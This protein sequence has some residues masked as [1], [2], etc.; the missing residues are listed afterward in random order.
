VTNV[1]PTFVARRVH[2]LRFGP[3]LL[4]NVGN[5]VS[6][7]LDETRITT[8]RTTVRNTLL[9][10]VVGVPGRTNGRVARAG[11]VII[12]SDDVIRGRGTDRLVVVVGS[13]D[14]RTTGIPDVVVA[15]SGPDVGIN[16]R[17]RT[18]INNNATSTLPTSSQRSQ[19]DNNDEG[20]E[21]GRRSQ[22]SSAGLFWCC[23]GRH[24]SLF[25]LFSSRGA[26]AIKCR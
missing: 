10:V 12:G 24:R 6:I 18:G 5:T 26:Q 3:S 13:D 21:G 17:R 14:R 15:V 11:T 8:E 22:R 1:A 25:G 2:G 16:N 23:G 20:E 9:L 7:V 19:R 4:V